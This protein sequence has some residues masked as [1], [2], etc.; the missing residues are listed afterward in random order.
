MHPR[1]QMSA[2]SEMACSAPD[3]L[4]GMVSGA[5]H[6]R[7]T[8][9]ITSREVIMKVQ[10][11]HTCTNAHTDLVCLSQSQML[12]KQG[13]LQG[14]KAQHVGL[15]HHHEGHVLHEGSAATESM[16]HH[17]LCHASKLHRHKPKLCSPRPY[18]I[19][20]LACTACD[21]MDQ[22]KV[23]QHAD[24]IVRYKHIFLHLRHSQ[25]KYVAQMA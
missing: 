14:G 8:Q 10:H 20:T 12:H 18:L 11:R 17:S 15:Q 23:C 13:I 9:L 4:P 24:S 21:C 7:V 6:H 19:I 25:E 1:A 2:L 5:L 16:W 22:A 3:A